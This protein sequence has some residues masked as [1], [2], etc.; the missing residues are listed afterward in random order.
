MD[1]FSQML[2]SML[3]VYKRKLSLER[4]QKSSFCLLRRVPQD[5]L[6]SSS[7]SRRYQ[8]HVASLKSKLLSY[9]QWELT[10]VA[11]L[12]K[13]VEAV[14]TVTVHSVVYL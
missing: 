11:L 2:L 8:R 5:C 4:D 3:P 14:S 13:A 9:K 6:I 12:R 10:S 7:R 1:S